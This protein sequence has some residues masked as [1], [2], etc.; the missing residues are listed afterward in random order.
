MVRSLLLLPCLLF[1]VFFVFVCCSNFFSCFSCFFIDCWVC[2]AGW[3]ISWLTSWVTCCE[4]NWMTSWLI[5]WVTC[6]EA[7]WIASWLISWVTCC[8]IGASAFESRLVRLLNCFCEKSGRVVVE[9]VLG[10][11]VETISSSISPLCSS[12]LAGS[13]CFAVDWRLFFLEGVMLYLYRVA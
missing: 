12:S 2:W 9:L 6:C 13:S 4:A 11:A 8:C 10:S 5:S 7:D 3:V 1:E